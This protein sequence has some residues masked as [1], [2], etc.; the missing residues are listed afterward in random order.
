MVIKGLLKVVIGAQ[1]F[2]QTQLYNTQII[3]YSVLL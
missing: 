1:S 2:T 3:G